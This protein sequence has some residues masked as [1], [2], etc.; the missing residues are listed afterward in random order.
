M[1]ENIKNRVI[2]ILGV[3]TILF[4]IVTINSCN[5][6]YRQK[7]ARDKEMAT[8]LDLEERMNKF[9]QE[10]NSIVEKLKTAESALE[11]EKAAAEA[12]KKALVQEQLINQSLKEELQKVTKLKD[13]LEEDLKEAL[14]RSKSTKPKK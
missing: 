6:A 13:A 5:N 4:F 12:T 11:E 9:S 8:R 7:T 14:V 10:K 3:L 1:E 2:L